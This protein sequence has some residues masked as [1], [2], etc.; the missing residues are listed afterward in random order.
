MRDQTHHPK[1]VYFLALLLLLLLL[2]ACGQAQP[3]E[4]PP[5]QQTAIAAALS[6]DTPIPTATEPIPATNTPAPSPTASPTASPVPPSPT[7]TAVPPTATTAPPEPT[8]TLPP[9][10]AT[11]P[12]TAVPADLTRGGVSLTFNDNLPAT[13][14][15]AVAEQVAGVP[16]T[17]GIG[18]DQGY[19]DHVR[20]WF[21]S[22][23][24]S[25]A[26]FQP[27]APQILVYPVDDYLDLFP[28]AQET[29]TQLE[30]VLAQ[31]PTSVEGTMPFLPLT[32]TSETFHA[33]VAYVPFRG[34]TA[35]RY[36]S[37]RDQLPGP[38]TNESLFYTFQGLSDDGT[39]LLLGFFPLTQADLPA[40]FASA[41]L[42]PFATE[43]GRDAYLADTT[44]VLDALA[45][46][47]FAPNLTELDTFMSNVNLSGSAAGSDNNA[48]L[49][50]GQGRVTGQ[51]AYPIGDGSLLRVYAISTDGA[52]FFF[53]EGFEEG[54]SL[55]LPAGDYYLVAFATADLRPGGYTTAVLCRAANAEAICDDHTLVPVAVTAGETLADININ[56]WAIPA[57]ANF[58]TP[59][60][61]FEATGP[62]I[63]PTATVTGTTPLTPTAPVTTTTPITTTAPVTPTEAITTTT[64]GG[65]V[66]GQINFPTQPIP[67]VRVYVYDP[68]TLVFYAVNT[69]AGQ[70]TY[71]L[72]VPPGRYIVFGYLP[73]GS[74]AGGYV[75]GDNRLRELVVE[76]GSF[77]DTIDID[78]W[79]SP[80]LGLIPAKPD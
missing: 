59:P 24:P 7:P 29:L 49:A 23:A 14:Q 78:N 15:R 38:I 46:A 70:T 53:T 54:Y 31:R 5:E 35:V 65:L 62:I 55:A 77:F 68:L 21:G 63:R 30:N 66:S 25:L 44:A 13:Y 75:E 50:A 1:P 76:T 2:A 42:A 32:G 80:P 4:A 79:N 67:A 43:S 26:V 40:D 69:A 12:P 71:E 57:D 34:G 52:S 72:T 9:P 58:P 22:V 64:D 45:P 60:D 6:T 48:P 47:D 37:Q 11:T 20:F 10:T 17:P 19:P 36:I 73:D 56:D 74:S 41:D 27:T 16:R 8:A 61:G 18:I 39:Q 3:D 33:Q 51:I 28:E